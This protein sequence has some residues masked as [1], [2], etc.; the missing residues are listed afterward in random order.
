MS[1]SLI[2]HR[3]DTERIHSE[4]ASQ[5][6]TVRWSPDRRDALNLSTAEVHARWTNEAGVTCC[7]DYSA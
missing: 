2:S 1:T 6:Q 5:I 4:W 7:R 3:F